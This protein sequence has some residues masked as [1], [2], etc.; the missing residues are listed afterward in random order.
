MMKWHPENEVIMNDHE[1]TI[2]TG[3]RKESGS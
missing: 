3:G 2:M 1:E